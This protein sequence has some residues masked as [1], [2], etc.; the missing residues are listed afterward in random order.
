MCHGLSPGGNRPL[1]G[2]CQSFCLSVQGLHVQTACAFGGSSGERSPDSGCDSSREP[3]WLAAG[4]KRN[5]HIF[6]YEPMPLALAQSAAATA[7]QAQTHRT[8]ASRTCP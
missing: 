7:G 6:L 5:I 8:H 3:R 2:V 4:T 1:P